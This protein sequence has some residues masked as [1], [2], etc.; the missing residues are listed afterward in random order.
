MRNTRGVT[1]SLTKHAKHQ[2]RVKGF[3]V[4]TIL[5]MWQDPDRIIPSRTYPGQYR[6]CG[7]GICVV[8]VKKGSVFIGITLYTDGDLTPPRPD[9]MKSKAGRRYAERYHNGEGRG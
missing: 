3:E 2:A 8:G 6:V 1:L 5:E 7:G 4:P 9:Q